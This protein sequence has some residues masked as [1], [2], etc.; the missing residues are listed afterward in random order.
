MWIKL[1]NCSR[2]PDAS[3]AFINR[4][5]AW[6][7]CLRA[8]AMCAPCHTPP[9]RSGLLACCQ[10]REVIAQR[11]PRSCCLKHVTLKAPSHSSH[12]QQI[13]ATACGL[14]HHDTH[15]CAR[16]LRTHP[17]PSFTLPSPPLPSTPSA[18]ILCL[19]KVMRYF[20]L[21]LK[22]VYVPPRLLHLHRF[23]R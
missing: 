8:R 6:R 12:Q 10:R 18:S 4:C 22:K 21:G 16:P 23:A 11:P 20:N 5:G 17:R 15:G 19:F 9:Q 13:L 3:N 14:N 7:R 1:F 2:D